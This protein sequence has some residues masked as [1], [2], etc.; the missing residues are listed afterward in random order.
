MSKMEN[1]KLY[2]FQMFGIVERR[3]QYISWTSINSIIIFHLQRYIRAKQH[4]DHI[5]IICGLRDQ[6]AFVM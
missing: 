6:I 1:M 3:I 4:L 5:S 2:Y